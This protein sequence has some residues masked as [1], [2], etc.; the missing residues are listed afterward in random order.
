MFYDENY[1]IWQFPQGGIKNKETIVDAFQRE[2]IEELGKNFMSKFIVGSH[3][4]LGSNSVKFPPEK[5]G[6]RELL[7]DGGKKLEMIGKWYYFLAIQTASNSFDK[8]ISESQF[9]DW[10]ILGHSEAVDLAKKIHQKGKQRI[11]IFALD[12]L[13]K[14]NLID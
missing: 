8:Q 6:S 7:D 5:H 12:L 1:G 13:K 10:R 14:D 9:H 11:T 2:M 3:K 4:L